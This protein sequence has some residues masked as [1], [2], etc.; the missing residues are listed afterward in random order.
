MPARSAWKGHMKLSLV[1]CSVELINATSSGQGVSFRIINKTTGNTVN[2]QYVDAATGRPVTRENEVKGYEV[3]KGR[4]LLMDEDEI[5]A[6]KVESSHTLNF[7]SFVNK[8]DI[9]QIYLDTPYYLAPADK[10]SREAFAVIRDAMA[11]RKVAGIAR[12][13]LY[14]RE[15]PVLIEP[16]GKGMLLTTLR[17]AG[18]V[19]KAS[20]AFDEI[21]DVEVDPEAIDLAGSIMEKKAGKFD[22]SRFDDRYEEA[23]LKLIEA[24]K[25]GRKPEIVAPPEPS[26]VVNLFDALKKSLASEGG[27][28][29]ARR[30]KPATPPSS[31]RGKSKPP[32]APTPRGKGKAA[33]TEAGAKRRAGGRR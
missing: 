13:V 32:P 33:A 29:P 22:P 31:A 1:T 6:V 20:V 19:K 8:G 16:H 5:A 3:E 30:S 17:F 12:I 15:R 26:N 28:A 27:D 4:Y 18:T 2:R 25:S 9:Q 11:E 24:K 21:E 10:V 23:L 7:E 14:G